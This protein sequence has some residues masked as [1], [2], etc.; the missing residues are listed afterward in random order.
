MTRLFLATSLLLFTFAASSDEFFYG[1]ALTPKPWANPL[2]RGPLRI[3]LVAP[4][5]TLGDADLLRAH[6]EVQLD[7]VALSPSEDFLAELEERLGDEHDVLILG[8]FDLS[9]L[10]ASVQQRILEQVNAGTGLL[11]AHPNASSASPLIDAMEAIP[12][13]EEVELPFQ[14]GVGDHGGRGWQSGR[15]FIVAG[16]HGEGRIAALAYPGDAPESHCLLTSPADPVAMRPVHLENGLSLVCR[17]LLWVA[18]AEPGTT[19]AEVIDRSPTGPS[20]EEIP[21]DLPREFVQAVEDSAHYQPLHPFEFRLSQPA[22]Q[23]YHITYQL[24]I[25]ERVLQYVELDAPIAKGME[26]YRTD[27]LIGPGRYWID[28]WLRGRKGIAAWYTQEL[29]VAGWPEV[30]DAVLSKESLL[31][32]DRLEIE[33]EIRPVISRTRA[34]TLYARAVDSFGRVVAET[35][36]PMGPE[37]GRELLPLELYDLIAPMVRVDIYAVEGGQR[38]FALWDAMAAPAEVHYLPVRRELEP[39]APSIAVTLP[40]LGEFNTQARVQQLIQQGVELIAAPS[41]DATLFHAARLGIR[42]MPRIADYSVEAAADGLAREPCLEDEDYRNSERVRL[43]D[44]ATFNASGGGGLIS[45]GFENCLSHSEENICQSPHC[46]AQFRRQLRKRYETLDALNSAW[47]AHFADWEEVAPLPLEIVQETKQYAPWVQFRGQMDLQFAEFHQFA[48]G[49]VRGVDATVDISLGL[50]DDGNS[51]HAYDLPALM[52]SVDATS[53][54][55]DPLLAERLHGFQQP[56]AASGL[57]VDTKALREAQTRYWRWESVLRQIPLV[58]SGGEGADALL[59]TNTMLPPSLAALLDAAEPVD[60]PVAVYYSRASR[61]LNDA[62]RDYAASSLKSEA[63]AVALVKAAGFQPE[64]I[65]AADP[66]TIYKVIILP[67]ARALSTEEQAVLQAYVAAGGYLIADLLPGVYSETGEPITPAPLANLF[68]VTQ[69]EAGGISQENLGG[70]PV[71]L[72]MHGVP[73]AGGEAFKIRLPSVALDQ[74]IT[75]EASEYREPGTPPLWPEQTHE[76]GGTT[77]FNHDLA[78]VSGSTEAAA[79][80]R[81]L[82]LSRGG[83]EGIPLDIKKHTFRGERFHLRFGH[84]EIFAL[85]AD[86]DAEDEQKVRLRF[87]KGSDVYDLRTGLAVSSP[88]RLSAEIAPGEAAVYAI[89]PYEIVAAAILAPGSVS[90]GSRLTFRVGIDTK[91]AQP[92]EHLFHIEFQPRFGASL[93]H[94]TRTV[95]CTAGFSETYLPL[96]RNEVPGE[97]ILR[98]RDV[99]TGTVAEVLV[100]VNPAF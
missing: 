66:L 28:V 7:T 5:Q 64:L 23:D 36:R 81:A 88:Q 74:R 87:P 43:E 35:Y 38:P 86:P 21:P 20:E 34:A 97:Y 30:T 67:A 54:P 22:D 98:A 49:I 10:S 77:L 19:V 1:A 25:A 62:D 44:A 9:L 90:A 56:G 31:A 89:L 58:W 13:A 27:I 91:G 52:A 24:R 46:L 14:H 78:D 11:L 18:D 33:V 84:A 53:V 57:V 83:G 3:L 39:P 63:A 61:H 26:S 17:A 6:L 100:Q 80:L 70:R 69:S 8:N 42:L 40:A 65:T 93:P 72:D 51:I 92:G 16:P 73:T 76:A 85:L 68:G 15:N 59:E 55:A 99:L 41:G 4:E 47:G 2:Q 94:Y 95:R 50:L 71:R 29:Q 60:T 32:N 37:G 48:A 12:I 96:A 75:Q 79:W 45:L 82:L